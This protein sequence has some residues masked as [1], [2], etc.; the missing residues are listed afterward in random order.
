MPEI[1]ILRPFSVPPL[2]FVDAR[3]VTRARRGELRKINAEEM[4]TVIAESSRDTGICEGNAADMLAMGC[5]IRKPILRFEVMR[6]QQLLGLFTIYN[7]DVQ[8]L[9]GQ[10]FL[11]SG[12]PL[13][14]VRVYPGPNGRRDAWV[15]VLGALLDTELQA[16]GGIAIDFGRFVFPDESNAHHWAQ[17]DP[18]DSTG[19]MTVEVLD[20]LASRGNSVDRDARGLPRHITRKGRRGGPPPTFPGP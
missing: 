14:G 19:A 6:A 20:I 13:A 2:T 11:L 16:E 17:R 12:M 4:G 3:T 15:G 18:G 5:N 8:E 9:S 10:E 1:P 7:T